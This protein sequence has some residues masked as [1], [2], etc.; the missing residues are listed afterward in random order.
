MILKLGHD[1]LEVDHLLRPELA[2]HLEPCVAGRDAA[3]RAR[4]PGLLI[5]QRL[6]KRREPRIL[7]RRIAAQVER[8]EARALLEAL[9]ED[10]PLG[11]GETRLTQVNGNL[12]LR[13]TRIDPAG[14]EPRARVGQ[15][16]PATEGDI[17]LLHVAR[18][19]AN[20]ALEHM[21]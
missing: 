12:A 13:G 21:L 17:G 4:M 6:A 9:G 5:A 1:Q 20:L 7:E 18:E 11:I 19:F 2:L 10:H 15:L 14:D 16:P 8:G 3:E